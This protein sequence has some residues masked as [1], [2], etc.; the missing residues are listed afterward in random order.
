MYLSLMQRRSQDLAKGP[1]AVTHT[2][3]LMLGKDRSYFATKTT[4]KP[5]KK[6]RKRTTLGFLFISFY[7]ITTH[8]QS[9]TLAAC[10]G[11]EHEDL[12]HSQSGTDKQNTLPGAH[13][14]SCLF[15]LQRGVAVNRRGKIIL[16]I[17]QPFL[18]AV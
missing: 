10:I 1:Q 2:L 15:N 18:S 16:Q 6:K 14:H 17:S 12:P 13:T 5:R 7:L 3:L 4:E 9:N 11:L 8:T